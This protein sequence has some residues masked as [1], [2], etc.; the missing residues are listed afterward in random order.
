MVQAR[1]FPIHVCVCF[2]P[3]L[4][5]LP[6]RPDG[7][8][9]RGGMRWEVAHVVDCERAEAQHAHE[10]TRVLTTSSASTELSTLLGDDERRRHQQPKRPID[11]TV[12][13][14]RGDHVDNEQPTISSRKCVARRINVGTPVTFPICVRGR[15]FACISASLLRAQWMK[16]DARHRDGEARRDDDWCCVHKCSVA[17]RVSSTLSPLVCCR[18]LSTF[19]PFSEGSIETMKIV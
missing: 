9:L 8:H 18:P 16:L 1:C 17:Q 6:Q 11:D 5:V 19:L 2:R 13:R 10:T 14:E 12:E 3:C 7:F 4:V 15:Y